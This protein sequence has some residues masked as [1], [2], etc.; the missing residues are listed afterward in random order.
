VQYG[1]TLSGIAWFYG[2]PL[3][4]LAQVNQVSMDYFVIAGQG[5][6]I[7]IAPPQTGPN[8]YEAMPGDTLVNIAYQCGLTP[9][10]LASANNLEPGA[11]LAPGQLLMIPPWRQ[12]YP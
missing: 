11:L 7:P 1:Q 3:A 10:V 9:A 12:V 2:V 8:L 5:L 6:F 4:D